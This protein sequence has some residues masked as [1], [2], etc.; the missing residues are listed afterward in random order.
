MTTAEMLIELRR[1]C[2]GNWARPLA[3]FSTRFTGGIWTGIDTH[4]VMPD[5]M[6]MFCSRANGCDGYNGPIHTGFETW[7]AA[8]SWWVENY[9]GA[10]FFLLPEGR[11]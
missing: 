1:L 4:N 3:E 11:Q 2:P 7:L 6:P 5:G 10:T 9:D 8:R